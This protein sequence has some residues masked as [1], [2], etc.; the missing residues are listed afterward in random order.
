MALSPGTRLGVYEVAAKIGEGGMGEVYRARDPRLNREIA[1]KLLPERLADDVRALERFRR[2]ARAV[3]A[4]NHPNVVTIHA[5]EEADGLHFLTM[6]LVVGESLK[7]VIAEGPAPVDRFFD[8]VL[9]L[10]DGLA[11]AHQAGVT[12][13]DLKPGN[14]MLSDTGRIKVLDF[15]LATVADAGADLADAATITSPL[16]GD[17]ITR[18]TVPYMSPEQLEGQPVDHR[19]DIFS[20]G[21]VMYELATGQRPFTGESGPSLMSAILRDDPRPVSSRRAGFP[22]DAARIVA[23]CLQKRLDDRYQSTVDLL[24][25]LQSARAAYE[26]GTTA[27][28]A[29]AD[30]PQQVE[31]A[32]A[33]L[34]F[35]SISPDPENEFFADGISEEL[36]NA[37]GHIGGLRV[38]AR[39]SAFSFKGKNVQLGEIARQLN[40]T[41]VLEGSV[42]KAGGQLRVTARLVNVGDGYQIW[43]E[44][45]DREMAD[46][47]AIQDEIARTIADRLTV[48]L[49]D[50]PGTSLVK[51]GTERS[52]AY[53]LYLK[54][55]VLL[56]Q[57]GRVI[58]LAI[59]CFREAVALD[60]SYAQAWAGLA[61]GH[62]T[63]SQYGL[64]DPA[65]MMPLARTEALRAVELDETLAEAQ[66][67]LGATKVMYDR[68]IV[69]AEQAFRRA[70]AINPR[71]IQAHGW[72][73]NFVLSLIR[74]RFE[75]AVVH[76]SRMM[77]LDPLSTYARSNHAMNL[78]FMGRHEDALEI[79][80]QAVADDPSAYLGHW[81]LQLVSVTAGCLDE[82][83]AAGQT[84][85]DMS[86]RHQWALGL[87]V[88]VDQ[89]R[90]E[91][92]E[93]RALHDEI[94]ALATTDYVLPS[95]RASSAAV[96][97]LRD[98]ALALAE[99]APDEHD[100][101]FAQL[102]RFFPNFAPLRAMLRETGT[103]DELER[104]LGIAGLD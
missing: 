92:A 78:A 51:R 50:D 69:G 58:P 27:G 36:I 57:R 39:T 30:A 64:A 96:V 38:A 103:F 104:R 93:A 15:G 35:A 90:G 46:V 10:C 94:E 84:A 22:S 11:A 25:D 37:L 20:M 82:A 34:P 55:R 52:D 74:G 28:I 19:S 86:G 3:A 77:D 26:T 31:K 2:E 12:H 83:H 8:I 101:V 89:Q 40:V 102:L 18:G 99:R 100:P 79:A 4:L 76:S 95:L 88:F 72:L 9:P 41:F 16:T 91:V 62:S 56:S 1:I 66:T 85:L 6:E 80:R 21:V 70:L 14:V 43:S 24:H 65:R 13:R 33:V 60:E 97:G 54:G 81:T 47:F 63:L 23:R 42:R 73:G 75:E 59:E 48:T 44:Q 67:A 7:E 68:D 98:D 5:V 17:G 53:E 71:Y 29:P 61:D 45:Y 32:I 49:S 87:Q